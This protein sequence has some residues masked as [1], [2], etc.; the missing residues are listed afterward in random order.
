[1]NQQDPCC[2]ICHEALQLPC[3]NKPKLLPK[4]A[5]GP[6]EHFIPVEL[7]EL[8]EHKQLQMTSSRMH[9]RLFMEVAIMVQQAHAL[10]KCKDT[11]GGAVHIA[12]AMMLRPR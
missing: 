6:L 11:L 1:M 10:A 8:S 3:S 7:V 9:Q 12:A 2:E 4:G 5:H